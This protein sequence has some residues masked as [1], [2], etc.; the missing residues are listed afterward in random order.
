MIKRTLV[1]IITLILLTNLASALI[2]NS[3]AADT[4]AP[5]QEGLIRIEVENIFDDDAKDVSLALQFKD[6]P[7]IPIGTS[8]QSTDE[9]EE[10]EDEDFVFRVK[11]AND[12]KPGDYEIPYTLTFEID[13]DDRSRSGTIGIKVRANPDLVFTADSNNAVQGRQSQINFK[14][15]NKGFFDA[16]FVSVRIIPEGFTLLSESEVYIGTVDSDDFETATFDA[17]FNKDNSDFVAVIEYIDFDNKKII[18]NVEIPLTVYSQEKAIELG[19]IKKSN[20][21]TIALILIAI[22]LLWILYRTIRRRQRLKRSL[23]NGN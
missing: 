22:I 7:F 8:E 12:A 16:R 15:I 17:R 5:G 4:L 11:T 21:L 23:R 2:I 14:I 9:I 13:N 20:T 19:I 10:D 3:V 6:I 18:E 1:F